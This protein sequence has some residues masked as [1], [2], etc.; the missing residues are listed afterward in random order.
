MEDS[1]SQEKH[2]WNLLIPSIQT[3]INA[4]IFILEKYF[5]GKQ[6]DAT[7]KIIPL[8]NPKIFMSLN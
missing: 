8:F 2:F 1:A 5:Q 4:L 6:F 7:I 3:T